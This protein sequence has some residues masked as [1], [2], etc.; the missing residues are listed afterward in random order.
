MSRLVRRSIVGLVGLMLASVP[1]GAQQPGVAP[2][3]DAAASSRRDG[4]GI[5]R[6]RVTAGDTGRPLRRARITVEAVDAGAQS[7]QTTSTGLDGR[8]EVSGLRAGRYKVSVTRG[9]YL[10]LEYGQRRPGEQGR[11]VQLADRDKVDTVDFALPRMSVIS[12]RVT[13]EF[14]EPIEGV[15][16]YAMRALFFDGQRR[17]VPVNLNTTTDDTGEYRI[18]R[19]A[20][21]NYVVM[22]LTRETWIVNENG[23]PVT[24][25]YLPTY[26]PGAGSPGE[27]RSVAL[28]VGQA[29]G[30]IDV[31]LL[32][33]RA[34]RVSGVATDSQGRPFMRVSLRDEVRG[35]NFASFRGGPDA[36][37]NADG[38]FSIPN[39]PPGDYVLTASRQPGESGDP[40]VA[41][42]PLSVGTTDLEQVTLVG[43]RGGSVA[44]QVVVDGA[45]APEMSSV[46]IAILEP[47]RGQPSPTLLGAFRGSSGF[48][49]AIADEDGRFS[50]DNVFGRARI[51]VT[52]PD[53]WMVRSVEHE[54]QDIGDAP[55]EL[56]S[57]ERIS[58]IQVVIT[59][60]VTRV[61]GQLLDRK[62]Q[63]L[64]DAT[65]LVFP[66]ERERWFES[67]RRMR[68]VRPDQRGEWEVKGLPPGEYLAVAL[69][70]VD[71]AGW[72]DPDYLE[73]LRES[74]REVRVDDG[75]TQLVPLTLTEPRAP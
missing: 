12:G 64:R 16:V 38:T 39:V 52:L 58:G 43:S 36:V 18:Q 27:A 21:G 19:L 24:Y 13:D 37:V 60:R 35:L 67:S 17:L 70:Y 40:E 30:A 7:R 34:P 69:E 32:P 59:D 6:G 56:G 28:G 62:N 20:P 50:V 11:P 47:T 74:A 1:A 45:T 46:R 2:P 51:Q 22:A 41:Q 5:I 75:T 26:F 4:T 31:A 29:L 61:F 23:A 66:R 72:I 9:G 44:G 53:G 15:A 71:N 33:G 73:S 63:P 14:G 55:I 54:G 25:A 3:R 65:V 48:A 49:T 68:A 10:P 57:G 42:L 8:F